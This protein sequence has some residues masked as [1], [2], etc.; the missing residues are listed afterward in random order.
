M[1]L[2]FEYFRYLLKQGEDLRPPDIDQG[3]AARVEGV[4]RGGFLAIVVLEPAEDRASDLFPDR[5]RRL[6]LRFL[7]GIAD[8]RGLDED[9][10]DLGAP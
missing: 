8:K 1:P 6:S 9:R 2:A 10:R 7:L 4:S 5:P 3:I